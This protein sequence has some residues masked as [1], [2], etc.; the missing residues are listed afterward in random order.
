MEAEILRK[1]GLSVC[2]VPP[3]PHFFLVLSVGRCKFKLDERSASLILQ[4]VIGGSAELFNVRSL[5]DRVFRFSVSSQV[6]GFH[7]YKLRSFEGSSF[8]IFFNLWHNGGPRYQGE[9]VRWSAEEKAKWTT[10]SRNK[11]Q[12]LAH[13]PPRTGHQPLVRPP[14]LAGAN[15]VPVRAAAPGRPSSFSNSGVNAHQ[16]TFI[17]K[18]SA[19]LAPLNLELNANIHKFK[20]AGILGARPNHQLSGPLACSRCLAHDHQR[21]SYRNLLRCHSCF[22]FGH[23]FAN[24]VFPPRLMPLLWFNGSVIP[25]LLGNVAL[26]NL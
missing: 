1:Y 24:C 18:K 23:S 3:S 6:V 26:P 19:N 9:F 17:R 11:H 8:K 15:S 14:P 7:I 22:C 25:S 12:P 10:V 20:Y 2:P 4:S 21:P 16:A 5:G 13:P